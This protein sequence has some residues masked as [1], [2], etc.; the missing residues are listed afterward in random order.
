LFVLYKITIGS[1]VETYEK[2]LESIFSKENTEF[3]KS[4][5]RKEIKSAIKKDRILSE[6]DAK[7]I[8][9]FIKKLNKELI[10]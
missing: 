7:L 3:Y 5:I 1:S 9:E 4:K 8:N 10:N 2:K 6:S